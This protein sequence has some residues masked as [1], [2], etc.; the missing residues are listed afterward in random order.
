MPFREKLKEKAIF[1][2]AF[3]LPNKGGGESLKVKSLLNQFLFLKQETGQQVLRRR[4]DSRRPEELKTDVKQNPQGDLNGLDQQAT[5]PGLIGV[6]ALL[7]ERNAPL[8]LVTFH[9]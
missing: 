9:Y 1:E 7:Y 2:P 4:R 8:G 5:P 3:L 6:K